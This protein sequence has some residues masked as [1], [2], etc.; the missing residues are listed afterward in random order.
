MADFSSYSILISAFGTIRARSPVRIGAGKSLSI[1]ESDL[2]VVKNSSGKPVI[3]GSS[4]KGFFREQLQ[5]ILLMKMQNREVDRLLKEIF[6]SAGKNDAASAIFFHEMEMHE[7]RIAERKHIAIDPEKGSV[8]KFFEVECVMDGAVF[9][10]RILSARNLNP[11]ALGLLKT[12]VDIS[13]FGLGRLGGFK[14]RGYGEVEIKVDDIRLIFPGKEIEELKKGFEITNLVPENFGPI[15]VKGADS[16]IFINNENFRAEIVGNR[17]FF[18]LEARIGG[19]EAVRFLDSMLK[20]V[21]L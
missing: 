14:S 19:E 13:N 4:L 12:V 2:P 3:P 10:G 20:L 1:M 6:G 18:G 15:K 8:D 9:K 11:K 21:K 16:E 5:K 7:G 17:S